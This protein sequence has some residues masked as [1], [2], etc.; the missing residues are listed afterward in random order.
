MRE[1]SELALEMGLKLRVGV[2]LG[3]LVFGNEGR[4]EMRLLGI[5]I[6]RVG[7]RVLLLGEI[8]WVVVVILRLNEWVDMLGLVMRLESE[9][10]SW[11]VLELELGIF[12][13][14]FLLCLF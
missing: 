9:E 2:D 8:E 6:F 11:R 5:D 12:D 13:F 4:V 14:I 3:V 7:N 1:G 10:L